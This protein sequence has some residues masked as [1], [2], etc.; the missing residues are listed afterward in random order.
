M[1]FSTGAVKEL[2]SD[3]SDHKDNVRSFSA[4]VV[5]RASDIA[6]FKQRKTVGPEDVERAVEQLEEDRK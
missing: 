3:L 6:S 1:V 2:V 4:R 5:E